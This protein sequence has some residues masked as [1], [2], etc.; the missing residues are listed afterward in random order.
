MLNCLTVSALLKTVI[1]VTSFCRGGWIFAQRLGC[2]GAPAGSEPHR[3]DRRCFRQHVQGDAQSAHGPLDHQPAAEWR[4]AD[5]RRYRE[6]SA[7]HPRHRNAG[8]EQRARPARR[9]RIRAA[10]DAGAGVRSAVQDDDRAAEGILGSDGQAEGGPPAHACQGVHGY[11]GAMLATLDK[12]SGTLAAAVNHQDATIDQLLAIKQIAWLL[13][14]T[15]GEASLIVS[16]A[17]GAGKVAPETRVAFTKFNGGADAAWSALELTASGMQLPPAIS[18]AMAATKTAYF[19]PQYLALR[20]RLLTQ[21]ASGEKAEMTANQWTPV[22]VGRLSAA[23][24]VAE[25][26]LDAAK[27]RAA[28]LHSAA[29]RS[30]VDA[31]RAADRRAGARPWRPDDRRPPRHQAAAQHARRHA[32]G[33]GR[34]PRRRYRLRRAQGRNRRAGRRAGDLQAAGRRQGAD[35]SAGARTQRRRHGAAA[36]DRK[37]CRRVREHGAPDAEPARR[38][39]RPDADHLGRPVDGVAPDQ[40]RAS[41]KPRRRPAR[42]R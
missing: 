38:G 4:C 17:L 5:G 34:R 35:R 11:D 6:I 20:E 15:G 23:V 24:G 8:D 42:P 16:N 18:S 40:R 37:P 33:R 1:L 7:Q 31:T 9:H 27:D 36:G 12:L 25:S 30:L 28:L 19:E 22:T 2:L 39:F 29:Q 3:P 41:R 26:A 32:Q 13:R 14:N 21:V 10:G